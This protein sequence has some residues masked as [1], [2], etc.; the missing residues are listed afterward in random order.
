MDATDRALWSFVRGDTTARSFEEW[1]YAAPDLEEN[2]G[3]D[4]HLDLLSCDYSDPIAVQALQRTLETRL[5]LRSPCRCAKW[6]DHDRIP[7]NLDNLPDDVLAEFDVLKRRT[8]WLDLARCRTCGDHWYIAVDTVDDEF[9]VLRLS[10]EA[11]TAILEHDDWPDNYDGL[12][13]VWPDTK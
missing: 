5:E 6:R 13:H 11:V 10:Q 2:C 12:D 8:P 9:L 1:V 3:K 4:L 7:M